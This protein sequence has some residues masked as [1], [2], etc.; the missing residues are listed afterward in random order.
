MSKKYAV[1]LSGCGRFDGSETKEAVLTLLAIDKLGGTYQCFAPNEK[2]SD[3]INHYTGEPIPGASRNMLEEAARIPHE[4]VSPMEN[5]SAKPFDALVI[6]GGYGA[7]KNLSNFAHEGTNAQVIPIVAD[8]IKSMVDAQ[9]PVGFICIAPTMIPLFYP[10][11]VKM[12]IGDDESTA[13]VVSQMGAEHVNCSA[14]DIVADERYKVVSTPAY[15]KA[16][17]VNEAAEGIEKLVTQLGE[18]A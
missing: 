13:K 7:A 12:T 8:A 14:K 18:W 9:K 1:I 6:P 15:M 17:K 2:Q 5:F 16:T 4:P 3:V 10:A 11:G